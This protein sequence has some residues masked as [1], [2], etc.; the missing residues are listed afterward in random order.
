MSVVPGSPVP[1]AEPVPV[2]LEEAEVVV[3][4]VLVGVEVLEDELA[5]V[6]ALEEDVDGTVQFFPALPLPL[7]VDLFCQHWMAL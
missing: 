2:G 5:E 6:D 3:R 7:D 1:D 4:D